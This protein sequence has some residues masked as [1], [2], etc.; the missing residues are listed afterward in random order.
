[1]AE[2]SILVTG[3]SGFLGR[4]LADRIAA[5]H[6]LELRTAGRSGQPPSLAGTRHFNTGELSAQTEWRDALASVDT[7][8][9]AAGR[10]HVIRDKTADPLTRFLRINTEATMH[11]A[12][13]AA[14]A[15]V[16]RFIFISSIKVNGEVTQPGKLFTAEDTPAPRDPYAI[17]KH[18]AEEGLKNI[19]ASSSM[20]LVIIRPPLIYGPGVKANFQMLINW[21]YRSRPLP[22]AAVDN[23]RSLV[24]LENLI[25]LILTCVDHPLAANQTFLVSDGDDLSIA[26]LVRRIG[27]AIGTPARLFPLPVWFLRAAAA[28]VGK[29]AVMQR[30]LDSLQVDIEKNRTL[31]NWHPPKSVDHALQDTARD[32][33]RS[34]KM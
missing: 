4:A 14:E 27:S 16:R 8:V 29:R 17:S 18:R 13:Q 15:G 5:G 25:D 21:I 10:A 30:L 19:A 3:A 33:L 26:E 31:L 28:T 22:L 2:P 20:E 9:H 1:M 34:R 12:R 24:A 6:R 11:L 23:R 7:L 32:F